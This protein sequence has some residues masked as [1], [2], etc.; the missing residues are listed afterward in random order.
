[1]LKGIE[2]ITI[3]ISVKNEKEALDWHKTLLVEVEIM[4]PVPGLF[5][6]QLTTTTWLQFDDTGYLEVGGGSTIIRFE[7]KDIEKAYEQA[8]RLAS[9]IGKI[10]IVEDIV[11]YFDFK[12]P[13]G[14]RLSFVQVLP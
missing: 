4:E 5:E 6:L 2:G 12:D 7:T 3:A 9:D 1:M 10:I 14:N 8:Q 13:P 11:K